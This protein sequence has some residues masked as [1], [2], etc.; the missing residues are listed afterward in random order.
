MMIA[1]GL[2]KKE[3]SCRQ[4]FSFSIEAYPIEIAGMISRS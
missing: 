2:Y 1:V 4:K 3:T